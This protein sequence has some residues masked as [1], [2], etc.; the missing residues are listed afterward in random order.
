VYSTTA[1]PG[2]LTFSRRNDP[3]L[4][5]GI[6]PRNLLPVEDFENVEV[7]EEDF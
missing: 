6:V 7:S 1:G 4:K 2:S 3:L 5:G